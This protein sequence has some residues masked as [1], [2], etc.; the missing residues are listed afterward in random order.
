M[1]S[2]NDLL[3][4]IDQ[5]RKDKKTLRGVALVLVGILTFLVMRPTAESKL[6]A[7]NTMLHQYANRLEAQNAMKDRVFLQLVCKIQG[8]KPKLVKKRGGGK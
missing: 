6:R 1:Q 3:D 5:Q 4:T 8:E 7:E 2:I